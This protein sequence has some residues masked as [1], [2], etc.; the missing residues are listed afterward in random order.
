MLSNK[1]ATFHSSAT[2]VLCEPGQR[3]YIQS[4]Y[5]LIAAL[6]EKILL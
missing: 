3:A 4:A 2:Q 1:A 5:H 6:T